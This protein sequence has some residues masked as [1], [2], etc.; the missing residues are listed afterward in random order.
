MRSSITSGR[1]SDNFRKIPC[2]RDVVKIAISFLK[3]AIRPLGDS[4]TWRNW[5][6]SI[7][8]SMIASL[9]VTLMAS[10]YASHGSWSDLKLCI[11]S[12]AARS[13]AR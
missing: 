10:E 8:S 12:G 7:C 2:G 11:V 13:S 4:A 1:V 5:L 9:N 3:A 6:F